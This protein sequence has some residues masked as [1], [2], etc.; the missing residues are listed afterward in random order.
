MSRTATTGCWLQ[1]TFGW[2]PPGCTAKLIALAPGMTVSVNVWVALLPMPLEAVKVSV[3]VFAVPAAGVPDNAAVPVLVP[4]EKVTPLG[5]VPVI[6]IVGFGAPLAVIAKLPDTPTVKVAALALVNAGAVPAPTVS[7]KVWVT[8]PATLVAV[9]VRVYVFAVPVLGVPD[10]VA[11]PV[12]GAR[13]HRPAG[14]PQR[15]RC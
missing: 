8:L 1:A 12:P 4:A 9:N 6:E 7:K 5:G 11:V 13:R 15:A 2:P 3:Y 10:S 14:S